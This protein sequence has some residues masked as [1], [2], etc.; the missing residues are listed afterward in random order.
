MSPVGNAVRRRAVAQR[1]RMGV[2]CDWD[3]RER[4]GP[5]GWKRIQSEAGIFCPAAWNVSVA[6]WEVRLERRR[7]VITKDEVL[8]Q[9]QELEKAAADGSCEPGVQVAL[10]DLAG[11]E[12]PVAQQAVASSPPWQQAMAHASSKAPPIDEHELTY[13]AGEF[14]TSSAKTRGAMRTVRANARSVWVIVFRIRR[15]IG[16][17]S[18]DNTLVLKH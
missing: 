13:R 15:F 4:G 11:V 9:E 18:A 2:V 14:A 6:A 16:G 5:R 17:C 1:S 3:Y 7:C 12:W 8:A 10:V